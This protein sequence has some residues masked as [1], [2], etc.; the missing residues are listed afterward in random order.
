[1]HSRAVEGF[2]ARHDVPVKM[3]NIDSND[4]AR[5]KV[6]E[7]NEGYAS[8]PTLVFPNGDTLTEPTMKQLRE[9][10]NIQRVSFWEHLKSLF[11]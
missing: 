1:M 3:I 2:M 11:R 8:V 7:I 9:K 5:K 6:M 4:A 10:L